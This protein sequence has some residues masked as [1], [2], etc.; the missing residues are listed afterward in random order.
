MRAGG[1]PLEGKVDPHP[2]RRIT[3]DVHPEVSLDFA[4]FL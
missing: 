2:D 1:S 4:E 3:Q